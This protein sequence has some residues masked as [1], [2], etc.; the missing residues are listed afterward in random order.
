MEVKYK[1]SPQMRALKKPKRGLKGSRNK[2]AWTVYIARSN[3]R[4]LMSRNRRPSTIISN[5]SS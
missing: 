4:S 1:K 2:R 5:I 3:G